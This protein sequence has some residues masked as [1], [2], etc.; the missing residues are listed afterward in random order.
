M[1][2][3]STSPEG[4][5]LVNWR[6]SRAPPA[7]RIFENPRVVVKIG[8]QNAKKNVCHAYSQNRAFQKKTC[9][10]IWG[11]PIYPSLDNSVLAVAQHVDPTISIPICETTSQL[12][13]CPT[14][15]GVP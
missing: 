7:R 1:V 5:E 15:E 3:L 2:S 11:I 14:N 10:G 4:Q 6:I 13:V 9:H 8:G 12:W